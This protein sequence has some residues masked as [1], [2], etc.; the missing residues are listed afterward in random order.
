MVGMAAEAGTGVRAQ[1]DWMEIENSAQDSRTRMLPQKTNLLMEDWRESDGIG[2]E[3]R[4]FDVGTASSEQPN[5][6]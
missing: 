4:W 3:L 6:T 1:R 5:L 2:M